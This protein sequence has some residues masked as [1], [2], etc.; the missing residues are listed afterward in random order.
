MKV[1]LR[2]RARG[3]TI[4]VV[5]LLVAAGV[6]VG[7]VALAFDGGSALTQ[8]R[9][10]QNA[11]EAGA[12][13]GIQL[14]GDPAA[15]VGS[16]NTPPGCRPAYTVREDSVINKINALVNANHGATVGNANYSVVIEYHYMVGAVTGPNYAPCAN[17][18]GPAPRPSPNPQGAF[19]PDFVDG[20]RVTAKVDNPTTFAKA[21][22]PSSSGQGVATIPVSAQGSGRIFPTCPNLEQTVISNT[23]PFTRFRPAFEQEVRNSGNDPLHPYVFWNS[24]S[25]FQGNGSSWKNII[26]LMNRSCYPQGGPPCPL[27]NTNQL[28]ERVDTRNG[29]PPGGVGPSYVNLGN[30]C[31]PTAN[32]A[33]MRGIGEKTTDFGNWLYWQWNGLINLESYRIPG[34]PGPDINWQGDWAET[35]FWDSGN[36]GQCIAN[37]RD[38]M[39]TRYGVTT[40]LSGPPLNFG[41]AVDRVVHL[42]GASLDDFTN[43]GNVDNTSAQGYSGGSWNTL[44]IQLQGNHYAINGSPGRVRF[45]RTVTIRFYQNMQPPSEEIDGLVISTQNV[46]PN[47][48]PGGQDCGWQPGM[49]VYTR[50]VTP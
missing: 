33:D 13:A 38:S 12:L 32:C 49:G 50:Q 17:C 31:P 11:A 26:S 42:Y 1:I 41:K 46:G 10:M 45:T 2:R 47:P 29:P 36:C 21:F 19:V 6:L 18:Y 40:E 37:P 34:H 5:G 30:P 3:Q 24:T 43:N 25:D 20:I 44:Q 35:Y 23:L 14:M 4:A 27:T 48:P 15:V 7:L 28:L 8:R 22:F 39:I 9:I 16:C